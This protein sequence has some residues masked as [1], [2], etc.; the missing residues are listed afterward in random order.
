MAF[1]R[2]LIERRPALIARQQRQR[3]GCRHAFPSEHALFAAFQAL[4]D[5]ERKLLPAPFA[6]ANK[7]IGLPT[8][9][10]FVVVGMLMPAVGALKRQHVSIRIHAVYKK[11]TT[12][13]S[14]PRFPS[15]KR[16]Q[17]AEGRLLARS[18]FTSPS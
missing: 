17:F 1:R 18:S 14:G 13:G 15:D 3:F 10:A 8:V 6:R 11:T 5:Q 4:A 7:G 2:R 12:R 9:E 16:V